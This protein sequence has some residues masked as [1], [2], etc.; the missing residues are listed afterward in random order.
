MKLKLPKLRPK[1]PKW[2]RE[3][4]WRTL[5]GA[6]LLA[7]VI[8]ISATLAVPLVGPG[9]AFQKMRDML[10]AN[11]MV[12][13]APFTPDSQPLPYFSPDAL[14]AVCRFDLAA[15]AVSV[16]AVMA[17]T[18]WAL[19]LHTPQGDN[20]YVLPAQQLRRSDVA[21]L[22]VP[23]LD[24]LTDTIPHRTAGTAATTQIASP[25]SEGLIILRAPLKGL[26]WR[27]E[28]EA[29]LRRASCMAVKR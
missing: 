20:F 3:I 17:D 13:L 28:T 19:S 22:V 4:G 11:S 23:G 10:P 15:G 9:A 18:G 29:A 12:V 21:F 26:A 1:L 5:V 27:A 6:A 8:H 25:V 7:G 14:Y 16:N 24:R 2:T